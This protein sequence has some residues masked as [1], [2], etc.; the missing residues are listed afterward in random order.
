[1][2]VCICVCPC[3]CVC[4]CVCTYMFVCMHVFVCM[5]VRVHACMCAY[6]SSTSACVST[7]MCTCVCVCVCGPYT[8]TQ[9]ICVYNT[10]EYPLSPT[11]QVRDPFPPVH[12]HELP[13][14]LRKGTDES[15]SLPLGDNPH[16]QLFPCVTLE[17]TRVLRTVSCDWTYALPLGR[18]KGRTLS[19]TSCEQGC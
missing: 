7:Y 3:A 17:V 10:I 6:V 11:L 13:P 16:T 8:C 1:M 15:R 9:C 18:V 19:K 2:C 12:R 14:V 4:A 5:C